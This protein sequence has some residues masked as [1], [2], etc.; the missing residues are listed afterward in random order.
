[1]HGVTTLPLGTPHGVE[2]DYHLILQA[3]RPLKTLDS[4]VCSIGID[5]FAERA[6]PVKANTLSVPGYINET[7]TWGHLDQSLRLVVDRKVVEV[8]EAAACSCAA[9]AD[10]E[11]L[12][13]GSDDATVRIW[14]LSHRDK[15]SS[16]DK[17]KDIGS[18][19]RLLFILRGHTEAVRC[20]AASR[21]WSIAVSGSDD[22][23]IS[24]WDLNR[25]TY[26]RS[27]S[28]S[29]QPPS[30]KDGI[31]LV[32]I[33]EST[34][35]ETYAGEEEH[36]ADASSGRATSR[37][38]LASVLHCIRSMVGPSLCFKSLG[39]HLSVLEMTPSH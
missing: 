17:D 5:N 23:S 27:I 37:V 25:G 31:R 7:V 34:V 13:T 4:A 35:S 18:A 28:Y 21:A 32:A 2:E 26:V 38:C 19:L 22:G 16:R 15:E 33:Q 10:S 11:S 8:A 30:S 36:V 14:R 6:F 24:I 20:V 39:Q 12:V 1:M 3:P 9:F 29:S